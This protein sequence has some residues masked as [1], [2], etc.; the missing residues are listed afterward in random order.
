MVWLKLL[1]EATLSVMRSAISLLPAA[2][3]TNKSES[4]DVSDMRGPI[5]PIFQGCGWCG[6][7]PFPIFY[8]AL[9][10]TFVRVAHSI[11][12]YGLCSM[13]K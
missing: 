11:L 6:I 1:H 13:A 12:P 5:S 3:V 7:P 4:I 8:I 2:C 10:G 9:Q